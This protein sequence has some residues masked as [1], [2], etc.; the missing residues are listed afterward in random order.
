[1]SAR[2]RSAPGMRLSLGDATDLPYPA[3]HFDIALTFTV[4]SSILDEQTRRRVADEAMRV[5]RRGGTLIFYD[6]TWNPTNPD[7]RGV[8]ARDLRSLFPDCDIDARRVTLAPPISRRIAPWSWPLA[9]A[10]QALPFLRSHL[11]ASVRKPD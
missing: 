9:S 5:L 6:F 7:V 11:L 8:G 10:L 1:M 3:G 2:E 4:L